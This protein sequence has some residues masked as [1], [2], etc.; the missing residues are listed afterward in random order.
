[1][2]ILQEV[3]DWDGGTPNH[4]YWVLGSGKLY[5]YQPW[6]GEAVVFKNPL[7][8][9]RSRRKFNTLKTLPDPKPQYPTVEVP[10]SAGKTYTVTLSPEPRCECAGFQ[11][12]G[13][14]KHINTAMEQA[15][16]ENDE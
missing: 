13:K 5:A 8:F 15:Q 2:K 12:R 1:M 6:G 4:I 14:C 11:F 3:T 16:T 10:G 7:T 9:E